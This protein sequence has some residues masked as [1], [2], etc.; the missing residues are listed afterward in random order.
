MRHLIVFATCG[1][2]LVGDEWYRTIEFPD[3][4]DDHSFSIT[5]GTNEGKQVPPEDALPRAQDSGLPVWRAFF[6]ESRDSF[7]GFGRFARLHVV[8][9]GALDIFLDRR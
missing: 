5:R 4:R 2:N 7:P 6:E 8:A 1:V 9:Q 3:R